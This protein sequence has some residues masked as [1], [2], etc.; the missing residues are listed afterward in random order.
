[1]DIRTLNTEEALAVYEAYV[2]RDF[3]PREIKPAA[4]IR[5]L[6]E[7][8]SYICVAGYEA[9]EVVVY[10]MCIHKG[11]MRFLDY[12]AV[13][14][15]KRGKGIGARFLKVVLRQF[16]GWWLW[17]VENPALAADV[18]EAN[19]RVS[20]I[21]FY[22]KLGA[23]LTNVATRTFGSDYRLMTLGATKGDTAKL[24]EHYLSVFLHM[25]DQKRDENVHVLS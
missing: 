11:S 19:H 9:G 10:A 20:R 23:R 7:E 18:E 4:L 17:E 3:E 12:F 22:E 2:P 5:T 16:D 6:L 21:R 8:G 15:D 24:K 14:P 13:A 1:M 25:D